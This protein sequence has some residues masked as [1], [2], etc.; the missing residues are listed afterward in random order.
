MVLLFVG[1]LATLTFERW[2][3]TNWSKAELAAAVLTLYFYLRQCARKAE[4][5]TELSSLGGSSASDSGSLGRLLFGGILGAGIGSTIGIA[6]AFGA[7][8]GTIPLAIVCGVFALFVGKN[9]TT[10][11]IDSQDQGLLP[12]GK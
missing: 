10:R 4:I 1:F 2:A 6:G 11:S 5:L 7:V 9:V 12:P 8:A 3:F